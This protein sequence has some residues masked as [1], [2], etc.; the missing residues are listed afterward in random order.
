MDTRKLKY[1]LAVVDH[2]GFN[3]AAEHLL[4][5]QPSLSQTIAGLEKE[6]GVPLFHRIG[7]RAVLSEAGKELVGPAR[8]VMRDLDAA[9]SAVESLQG[10]RSGRLDIIT[11]PSPGIEPLTSMIAAFTK[12]YP[13]V[14]LNVSAA[15]TPEEVIESVRNGSSEIGLAGS[16]TPIL[17][18][19]VEVIELEK[20]PLILIVNPQADSFGAEQTAIQREDL[21]GQR[22]IASQRGS[23]MRWLVDDA[24]AH[25]VEVEIVVEVAH[26]TSILP[27]VLAG[28]GH[29]VM[30]SSWAP[31]A[32]K[33]GLRTMLIEPVTH[34]DVAV[35]SRKDNL[36]PA[37][38]AFLKVAAEHT[39]RTNN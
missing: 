14:R 36:T 23:L 22:I 21:G 15:F 28:V 5:A 18:P 16:P 25:G 1:F 12:V 20:Q 27:L 34:L 29:A 38:K 7:R 26:R 3:R 6:L 39:E 17:V 31:T 10:I 35:L 37:A 32:H 19:G 8:L 4:I 24:L 2:D 11:M 33:A 13:A 9:Q 30:P